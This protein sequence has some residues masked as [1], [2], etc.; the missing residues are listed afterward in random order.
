MCSLIF[1]LPPVGRS[2]LLVYSSEFSFRSL[3]LMICVRFPFHSL[4][5]IFYAASYAIRNSRKNKTT[6]SAVRQE[7]ETWK[8]E[9]LCCPLF[10]HRIV[11]QLWP[12][13]IIPLLAKVGTLSDVQS[14]STGFFSAV[15]LEQLQFHSIH[16]VDCKFNSSANSVSMSWEEKRAREEILRLNMLARLFFC[17]FSVFFIAFSLFLESLTRDYVVETR[18]EFDLWSNR[19]GSSFK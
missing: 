3:L 8:R 10:Y 17:W 1:M 9:L 2:L 7:T 6:S 19:F 13:P 5:M 4:S 14:G 12:R 16:V 18:E 11:L 15:L